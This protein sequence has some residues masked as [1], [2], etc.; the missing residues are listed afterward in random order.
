[1]IRGVRPH[2]VVTYDPDGGYGHPDH[3]HTHLVTT[4]PSPLGR[5]RLPGRAVGG[6]EA[7]LDGVGSGA[8]AAGLRLVGAPD[9]MGASDD[10]RHPVRLPRRQHRRRRRSMLRQLPAKVAALPA[11][12]TQVMVAPTGAAARC[13]TTSRC[14]SSPRSTT[15]SSSGERALATTAA[16]RPTSLP[17]WTSVPEGTR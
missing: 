14:P 12:A 2:V 8:M 10:Q 7:L 13:P 11:H 3:I 5:R 16:G 4:E 15:Y 6:A 17:V 1:M 9:D